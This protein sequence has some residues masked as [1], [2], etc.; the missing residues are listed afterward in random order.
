MAIV[1][2]PNR[3]GKAETRLVRVVKD[4]DTHSL[5]DLKV[6]VA[7]S[8]DLTARSLGTGAAVVLA[9]QSG[10]ARVTEVGGDVAVETAS[11]EIIVEGVQ[12]NLTASSAS[13]DIRAIRITGQTARASTQSGDVSLS[14]SGIA[15][16]DVKTVSGQGVV[17]NVAGRSLRMSAVSGDATAEGCAFEE[18]HLDAVSGYVSASPHSPLTS[19][20]LSLETISGDADLRLPA[21]CAGAMDVTTKS[22]DVDARFLDGAGV[23]K[24]VRVAG[25]THLNETLGAGGS[26]VKVTIS[27]IS[28]DL[29][30]VQ[31]SSVIEIS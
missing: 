14:E 20:V 9:T 12:G 31:D 22:G 24:T 6:S 23:E 3:Y 11:G 5:V 17:R 16:V 30:I 18:T 2:G 1:L 8:G 19:G 25:M 27:T 26:G 29:T 28:G 13:G 7:L 10:D 4:G 15:V 21:E